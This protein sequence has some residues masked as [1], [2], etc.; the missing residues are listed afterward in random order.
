MNRKMM[1]LGV[2]AVGAI[3][4]VFMPTT[5]WSDA[6]CTAAC[7]A[8]QVSD[9]PPWLQQ[10]RGFP[11]G[12][13]SPSILDARYQSEVDQLDTMIDSG[14]PEKELAAQR[15]A[16][17]AAAIAFATAAY[18]TAEGGGD[19]PKNTKVSFDTLNDA[20]YAL[21]ENGLTPSDI[22]QTPDRMRA[23]LLRGAKEQI[24]KEIVSD[25]HGSGNAATNAQDVLHVILYH[26]HF[27]PE[28]FGLANDEV[29]IV[30]VHAEDDVDPQ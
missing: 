15:T 9:V 21:I 30:P 12:W 13:Q 8:Q 19:V 20:V 17:R 16:T 23:Q 22:H 5:V 27:P 26:Y 25:L 3:V 14:K 24:T 11:L 4:A 7:Q 28:E 18:H 29:K 6:D 1:L 10:V 2:L